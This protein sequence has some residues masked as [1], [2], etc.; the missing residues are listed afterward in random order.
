MAVAITPRTGSM[1]ASKARSRMRMNLTCRRLAER[2]VSPR[3]RAQQCRLNGRLQQQHHAAIGTE[4]DF[5]LQA[6]AT[7]GHWPSPGGRRRQLPG[8]ETS[9]TEAWAND[10]F[11]RPRRTAEGR[12]RPLASA[13]W[14]SS[15]HGKP[16]MDARERC[17][18][19]QPGRLALR[20]HRPWSAGNGLARWPIPVAW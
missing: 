17:T 11:R 16:T 3:G 14:A 9:G 1:T 15:Q 2:Q 8:I 12:P 5:G 4:R 13:A 7:D 20:M 6:F 10:R 18:C 19:D